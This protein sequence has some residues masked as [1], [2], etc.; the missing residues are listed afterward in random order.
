MP[1]PSISFKWS[2]QALKDIERNTLLGMFDM[3]QDIRTQARL[4]AP[5]LDRRPFE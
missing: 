1:N 5:L 3:A 2:G 4:N